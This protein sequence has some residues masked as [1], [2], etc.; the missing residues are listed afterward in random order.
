MCWTKNKIYRHLKRLYRC[1]GK[2]FRFGNQS[3]SVPTFHR[4]EIKFRRC[5]HYVTC[6][7]WALV[8]K[9]VQVDRWIST[10]LQHWYFIRTS[11]GYHFVPQKWPD[12]TMNMENVL[13]SWVHYVI[14]N[15]QH[16]LCEAITKASFTF[17]IKNRKQVWY[18]Q[19]SINTFY[20]IKCTEKCYKVV[21]EQTHN[22]TR[23]LKLWL[24]ISICSI[25][26]RECLFISS[27][28]PLM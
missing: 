2:F 8:E 7:L 12:N 17:I 22:T 28:I 9:L 4:I 14:K 19:I 18:N 20:F 5:I 11:T 10:A 3:I 15:A 24:G 26:Y 23:Q 1:I 27:R 16:N 6:T 25:V 21:Q 13:M